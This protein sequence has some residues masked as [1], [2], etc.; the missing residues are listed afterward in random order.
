MSDEYD[1]EYREK[2]ERLRNLM[3]LQK[4]NFSGNEINK[5]QIEEIKRLDIELGQLNAVRQALSRVNELNARSNLPEDRRQELNKNIMIATVTEVA[6]VKEALKTE[7]DTVKNQV[8]KLIDDH[9]AFERIVSDSIKS[10]QYH[11]FGVIRT[12][13][14]TVIA[15]GLVVA[16]TVI[17]LI[18]R[19]AL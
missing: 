12:L 5:N 10:F 19:L 16:I 14:R 1:R 13:R 3:R 11:I 8:N 18:W 7:I 6:N 4:A 15:I 9:R 2:S 17:W